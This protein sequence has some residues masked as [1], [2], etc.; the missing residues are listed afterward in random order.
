MN[1]PDCPPEIVIIVH[2]FGLDDAKA[3][4]RFDRTLMS[5]QANNYKIP[6][7][8]FSW[9]SNTISL[10]M[11]S[12]GSVGYMQNLSPKIMVQSLHNLF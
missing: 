4:E 9:D 12:D 5:L 8:G 10:P 11:I 6:L 1:I 3:A 7:I 2:G